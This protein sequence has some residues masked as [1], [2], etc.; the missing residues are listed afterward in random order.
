[1]R[2]RYLIGGTVQG[3]GFRYFTR[4][5]GLERGLS[6]WVRNLSDG[7]VEAEAQ[8]APAQ[9]AAFEAELRRGP[10]GASVTAFR[11]SDIPDE[12]DTSSRFEIR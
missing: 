3:V 5:K 8:G 12:A 2:R 10:P 1:M 7:G 9:L 6:G 4:R 11:P